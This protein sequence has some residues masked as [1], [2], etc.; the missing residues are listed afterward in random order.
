[1]KLPDPEDF[2]GNR[3]MFFDLF[4]GHKTFQLIPEAKN[5]KPPFNVPKVVEMKGEQYPDS[6]IPK[7]FL[8]DR[9]NWMD[10]NYIRRLEQFNDGGSCISLT[11]NET[12]KK[13]RK[14]ENV[15]KIRSCFSD[16]DDRPLP[17]SFSLEPTMIVETSPGKFHI[18]W[19]VEN[20][21][22]E[23]FSQTQAAIA[24]NL[25]SDP[26]VKDLSRA[27]R[28]PG[29]F[30]QKSKRF[31]SRIIQYS[32][33]KY[34]VGDFDIFPPEPAKQW[35]APKWNNKD[36][37]DKPFKGELGTSKGGRNCHIIKR[38]GGAKK[39]GLSWSQ[40]QKVAYDEGAACE[41]PLK[42]S[43]IEAILKSFARY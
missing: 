40:I 9:S 34:S 10:F 21:P 13:G 35:S 33:L 29:F 19:A 1:M 17:K 20:F 6:E 43:E 15:I 11:I 16:I 2:D 3:K 12:N 4:P 24:F 31:L 14:G 39:R 28:C 30:H 22:I 25:K 41:P 18:F 5:I 27:L 7:G 26:A 38:I 32:G 36:T 23:M 42:E 8:F 37:S